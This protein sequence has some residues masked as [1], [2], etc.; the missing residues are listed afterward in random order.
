MWSDI[1]CGENFPLVGGGILF[2]VVG[3]SSCYLRVWFASSRP[4]RL[5]HRASRSTARNSQLSA[6]GNKLRD[7]RRAPAVKRGGGAAQCVE[8]VLVVDF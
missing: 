3:Q 6:R 7:K 8:T 2:L 4:T 5:V 1:G